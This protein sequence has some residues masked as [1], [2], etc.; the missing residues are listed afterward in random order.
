MTKR[1]HPAA[2]EPI[3]RKSSQR[4][5]QSPELRQPLS[6]CPQG[7]QGPGEQTLPPPPAP[8]PGTPRTASPRQGWGFHAKWGSALGKNTPLTPQVDRNQR[9]QSWACLGL[10]AGISAPLWRRQEARWRPQETEMSSPREK[11][12]ERDHIVCFHL[13]ESEP[14]GTGDGPAL[15]SGSHH[16]PAPGRRHGDDGICRARA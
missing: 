14:L 7:G 9:R 4:L 3:V 6:L 12:G 5:V 1:W 10:P 16:A 15:G 13:V 8:R 2:W 11:C